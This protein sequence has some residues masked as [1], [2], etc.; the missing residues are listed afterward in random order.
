MMWKV[1]VVNQSLYYVKV[2]S[3]ICKFEYNLNSINKSYLKSWNTDDTMECKVEN[4][5]MN[6]GLINVLLIILLILSS[7]LLSNVQ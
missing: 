1:I 2:K 4:T 7:K 5:G 6:L 3:L